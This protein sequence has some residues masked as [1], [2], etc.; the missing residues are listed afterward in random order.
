M[1]YSPM[2]CIS[3]KEKGNNMM[4]IIK[5][6]GLFDHSYTRDFTDP[7]ALH[8]FIFTLIANGFSFNVTTRVGE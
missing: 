8:S 1:A 3:G 7:D 6:T 4:Y 2:E 5:W